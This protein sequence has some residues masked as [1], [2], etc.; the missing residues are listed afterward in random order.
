MYNSVGLDVLPETI[1][2]N[3]VKTLA[4]A[5]ASTMQEWQSQVFKSAA[6]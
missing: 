1:D 6:K 4:G 5:M 3:D 2:S